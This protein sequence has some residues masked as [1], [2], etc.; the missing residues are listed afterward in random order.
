[1]AEYISC[2]CRMGLDGLR[3]CMVFLSDGSVT[4][5]VRGVD[6]WYSQIAAAGDSVDSIY[7]FVFESEHEFVSAQKKF[8]LSFL[9]GIGSF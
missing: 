3:R 9:R 4:F 1:M 7:N 6:Q 5:Y 8:W 2:A